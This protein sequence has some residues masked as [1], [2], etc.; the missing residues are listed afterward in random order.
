MGLLALT[1]DV[2]ML[3]WFN[4]ENLVI[5]EFPLISVVSAKSAVTT[6]SVEMQ[7]LC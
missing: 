5:K 6:V 1:I 4:Q 7:C 3:L 2:F